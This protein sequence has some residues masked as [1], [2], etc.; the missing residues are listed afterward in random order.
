M[1][2]RVNFLLEIGNAINNV[3][4]AG[5]PSVS[6]EQKAEHYEQAK[7]SVRLAIGVMTQNIAQYTGF[8]DKTNAARGKFFGGVNALQA[9]DRL[10]DNFKGF[11]ADYQKGVVDISKIQAIMSDTSAIA[12]FLM[13]DKIPVGGIIFDRTAAAITAISLA[14]PGDKMSTHDFYNLENWK[15]FGLDV[16][17][18]FSREIYELVP[19]KFNPWKESSLNYNQV[20]HD[21]VDLVID[22]QSNI[23]DLSASLAQDMVHKLLAAY[24]SGD[25][26]ALSLVVA[27]HAYTQQR[28]QEVAE[29]VQQLKEAEQERAAEQLAEAQQVEQQRHIMIRS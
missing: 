20:N 9:V 10:R 26:D 3:R 24:T 29:Q 12:S 22:S 19:D 25:R 8:D 16:L 1:A 15:G 21:K 23:K 14:Y 11:I 28:N 17:E 18:S 7:R 4:Q 2:Y 6:S 5:D 13:S 27:N